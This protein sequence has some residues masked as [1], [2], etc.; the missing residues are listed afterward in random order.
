MCTLFFACLGEFGEVCRGILRKGTVTFDVAVKKLK[1]ENGDQK[2]F[3]REAS[4]MA[5]FSHPNIVL[6][7]GVVTKGKISF[8]IFFYFYE[9]HDFKRNRAHL[10]FISAVKIMPKLDDVK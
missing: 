10:S 7:K 2:N 3:L 1:G 6:L 9:N 8:L 5:Q 4:T